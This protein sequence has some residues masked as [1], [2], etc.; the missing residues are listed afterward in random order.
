MPSKTSKPGRIHLQIVEVLK[1]YPE[2][3]TGGQI[4]QELQKSGL[5]P[6]DQTHLD[7]R[8]RDLKKRFTIAKVKLPNSSMANGAHREKK[9]AGYSG[10]SSDASTLSSSDLISDSAKI[11]Q[12]E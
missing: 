12:S 7:R 2:G 4:R 9:E 3:A 10:L 11:W 5:R 6:E 8:K 1:H